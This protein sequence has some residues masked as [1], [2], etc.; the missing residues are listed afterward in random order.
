MVIAIAGV[1]AVAVVLLAVPLGLVLER[2]YRDEELLKLQRDA[3]AATRSI[4][5]SGRR[6]DPIELP[7]S[8]DSLSVYGSSGALLAGPGP[9]SAPPLVATALRDGRILTE[10]A[11]GRLVVAVPLL[12][13]ERTTGALLAER[14]D[15]VVDSRESNTVLALG[16]LA[17]G[18]V[19][20]AVG[21]ALIT[22]RRLARPLEHLADA[23]AN[24][25]RREL[26]E[27]LP[28]AG[29]RELDAVA[30]ALSDSARRLDETLTRERAFSSDASHQLRTPLAAL[31]LELESIEL[32]GEPPEQVGAAL[33]QVDRL[34]AT[35]DTLLAVARDAPRA[36]RRADLLALADQLE[37]SWRARLAA[38][39]RPIRVS[40]AGG[41]LLAAADPAVVGQVL[42][43][44]ID[45]ADRHGGG[46]VTIGVR[47][48]G[49]WV[50]I[51]VSDEGPG[52]GAEPEL[53]FTRQQPSGDGHGIGL[54]L[55]RSLAEAEGGGLR[56]PG[57]GP[58]PTLTL[59]LP[60]LGDGEGEA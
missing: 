34:Q 9:A 53:A 25:D 18:I 55:A 26:I 12:E 15:A 37:R 28:P 24:V 59:M 17:A 43:V 27:G 56:A 36:E 30:A 38:K 33:E 4:D 19:A 7:E 13:N 54:S 32:E 45:N 31:R 35:I 58:G 48:M 52:F 10:S 6:G 46:A 1:A 42:D 20:L 60:A 40:A 57:V 14:D 49:G 22:A 44:L 41:G 8:A 29:V 47:G 23:A 5:T 51:D 50:A 11:D 2:S 16:G 39:G 21:A 3:V